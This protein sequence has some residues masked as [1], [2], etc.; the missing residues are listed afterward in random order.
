VNSAATTNTALVTFSAGAAPCQDAATIATTIKLQT[1]SG[2]LPTLGL[3]SSITS[4]GAD[5]PASLAISHASRGSKDS[6]VCNGI[7]T[8]NVED[9]KCDC[10]DFYTFADEYGGDC[11]RPI[12][13]TSSWVGVETCPG[14]VFQSD[15]TLDVPK[16]TS[17]PRLYV[18]ARS[19]TNAPPN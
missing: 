8:C 7:G 15:L 9:G 18:R 12:V 5:S 16:P 1:T 10:G 14:V 13:N 6:K 17:L 19:L 11:G 3:I 4:A 2:N